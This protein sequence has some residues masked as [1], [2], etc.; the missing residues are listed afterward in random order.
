M[1]LPFPLALWYTPSQA[2]P[3]TTLI[4]PIRPH[5]YIISP[6][7]PS[8]SL[9]LPPPIPPI[10]PSLFP[11]GIY[12]SAPYPLIPSKLCIDH[13]R[14][15]I[16]CSQPTSI[17]DMQLAAFRVA[18]QFF[19]WGGLVD[20]T[21]YLRCAFMKEGSKWN[22]D[23]VEKCSCTRREV[24]ESG[25]DGWRDPRYRCLSS[26][27]WMGYGD[28]SR[29]T[30]DALDSRSQTLGSDVI[31]RT[32]ATAIAS[33][34]TPCPSGA[35]SQLYRRDGE[36]LRSSQKIPLTGAL[37]PRVSGPVSGKPVEGSGATSFRRECKELRE[38]TIWLEYVF[39]D[40][41]REG[42]WIKCVDRRRTEGWEGLGA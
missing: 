1:A 13:Q 36:V 4:T 17:P 10:A 27:W 18:G 35:D 12:T 34:N 28:D 39:D 6:I 8:Q 40:G 5:P 15:R 30:T 24:R 21:I 14:P 38:G 26:S 42:L 11:P 7:R 23:G 16:S 32:N 22:G 19:H 33:R 3:N 25:C 29:C 31:E 41:L 20:S 2:Q 37:R 9:A